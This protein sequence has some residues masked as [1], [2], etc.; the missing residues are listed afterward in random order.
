MPT[1]EQIA[2]RKAIHELEKDAKHNPP[3]G[4]DPVA[5][6]GTAVDDISDPKHH[7]EAQQ[8]PAWVHIGGDN[9]SHP[10]YDS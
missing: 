8:D 1:P 10:D 6:A 3:P 2:A 7:G 4:G 5:D 9:W